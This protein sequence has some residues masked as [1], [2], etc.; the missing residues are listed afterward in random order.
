MDS[1]GSKELAK[2]YYETAVSNLSAAKALFHDKFFPEAVFFAQQA[3]EK[4][5]KA[6]L[7]L[8][9]QTVSGHEV[10]GWL[11]LEIADKLDDPKKVIQIV[12]ELES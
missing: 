9:G 8:T 3:V 12:S 5:A 10:S 11:A 1:R 2:E 7:I 6:I 4:I